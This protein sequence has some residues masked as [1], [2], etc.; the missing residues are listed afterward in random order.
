[1]AGTISAYA[2]H[3]RALL[4]IPAAALAI[5]NKVPRITIGKM[6]TPNGRPMMKNQ[7]GA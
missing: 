7:F 5:R 2:R 3:Q 6:I 4:H 1:V